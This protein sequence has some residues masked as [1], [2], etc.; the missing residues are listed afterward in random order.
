MQL[1]NKGNILYISSVDVSLGNGPA[2]NE[3]EFIVA[4]HE[5]I[6]NRAHFLIPRP[7]TIPE[8]LPVESCTFTISYK[9]RSLFLYP[10][11]II[12]QIKR[13]KKL[14]SRHEFDLIVFRLDAM[15]LA[16]WYI[17]GRYKIPYAVKTLGRFAVHTIEKKFGRL[18]RPLS[19]FNKKAVTRILNNC[20][21]AD[22]ASRPQCDILEKELGLKDKTITWIDNS[23]NIK[24]FYP[25]AIASV[26]KR[27]GLENSGPIIGYAGNYGYKRGARQ[28]ISAL[29]ELIKTYPDIT[30]VVLG[31][32]MNELK[33]LAEKLGVTANCR[34]IGHVNFEKVADYINSF[35]IGISILLKEDSVACEQKVRQYIACGKPVICSP[36]SND[37]IVENKLG[38]IIEPD[39]IDGLKTEIT[40]WLS[41]T[42]QQKKDLTLRASDYAKQYLSTEN[43]ISARLTLWSNG[44]TAD[45][46]HDN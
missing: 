12:S 37:F 20:I 14:I 7:K 26:R 34:L 40:R 38:S 23:V 17:T 31:N 9:K 3:L 5:R 30:A 11:H 6:G 16:A 19:I 45:Y 10:F 42:D 44:L 39:D 25:V 8:D 1:Q 46:D 2:V 33:K 24:R 27:T 28:L 32:N 18:A 35:D 22:A 36:G 41:L 29:P 13:F 43:S 15:P 4:L 21:A